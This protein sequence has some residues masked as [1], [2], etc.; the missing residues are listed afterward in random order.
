MATLKIIQYLDIVSPFLALFAMFLTKKHRDEKNVYLLIFLVVQ[1]AFNAF[2][3]Y[4]MFKQAPSN[5]IVYKTNA[6]FSYIT[7]T[8]YLINIYTPLLSSVFLK[9]IKI[10]SLLLSLPFLFIL[11]LEDDTFFASSSFSYLSLVIS[12]LCFIFYFYKLANP[13]E[14]NIMK[15]GHFW[16]ISGLL[17]Y[18]AGNFFIFF[19]YKIFTSNRVD[20]LQTLWLIHNV[21]FFI[22]SIFLVFSFKLK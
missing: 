4:L 21:I 8:A 15:S 3:K 17:L 10:S 18:Y 1:I 13:K 19:Y 7:V 14:E 11:I 12:I 22:M 16:S 6:F 5:I 2:A 20:D 9:T